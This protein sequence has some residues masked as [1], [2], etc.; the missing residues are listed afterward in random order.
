MFVKE[1]ISFYSYYQI[2]NNSIIK[3]KVF[4]FIFITLDSIILLIKII[5]I[6]HTNYNINPSSIKYINLSYLMSEFPIIIKLL[7]LIIYLILGYVIIII[8]LLTSIQK[9]V[10]KCDKIVINIFEFFIIR[11]LFIFIFEL[12]FDLSSYLFFLFLILSMPFL[13]FIFFNF[14]F[15]H[16]TGFMLKIVEFPYDNFS[17]ICE[18]QKTFIKIIIAISETTQ[19]AI[20]SK[21]M[22]FFQF[23]IMIICLIY[24]TYVIF[25]K[26]YYLMN[27]ELFSKTRYSN[28]LSSVVIQ[29]FMFLLK[30]E[31]IYS[32]S[33]IINFIGIYILIILFIFL[34]YNPYNY[35][36]IDTAEN[37]ENLYYY[38]FLMDRDKNITIFLEEKI[39]KHIDKCN[40]CS[41]CDKYQ[42]YIN[43]NIIEFEND[44]EKDKN[45]FNILYNGND[46]SLF[47]FN[48]MITNVKKYGINF[49]YHN[50]YY[51]INLINLFYY[52]YKLGDISFSLNLLLIFNL[53]QDNY[54]TIITNHKITIRQITYLNEFLLLYK[55]I[56]SEIKGII[57]VNNIKR[58][59][60]KFFNLSQDLKLLSSSKYKEYLY[61][62][63]VKGVTNYS[64]LLTIS[65]L[66]YEEIFNKSISIYGIPVRENTQLHE[67]ALKNFF[68]HNNHIVL[69]FNLKTKEC[70]ILFAGTDLYSYANTNFYDLF[71]NQMKEALIQSFCNVLLNSNENQSLKRLNKH[72][73]QNRRQYIELNLI[74]K[75]TLEN[76]N[77]FWVLFLKLSLLFNDHMKEEIL[78]NGF[79]SLSKNNL[80]TVKYEKKK[81]KIV[82][83]G[84]KSIMEAVIKSK[85]LLNVFKTSTF[86]VNK[87]IQ[88]LNSLFIG[89]IQYIVY[90]IKDN[91]KKVQIKSVSRQ[92]TN[93]KHFLNNTGE[94]ESE[95]FSN[96][97]DNKYENNKN[98]DYSSSG[99]KEDINIFHDSASQTSVK[100]KSSGSS[101]WNLNKDMGKDHQNSFSSNKFLKLQIILGVLLISSL[102]FM[103]V[104]I[105]QLKILQNS[106]SIY[107]NSFFNL[108]QFIRTFHQ[109]S[110]SL[111]TVACIVKNSSDYCESYISSL[112]TEEFNQTTFINE[113][114]EVLAEYCSES[115]T[116]IIVS[117]EVIKDKLLIEL[118]KGSF[119]YKI[120]NTKKVN[121]TYNI[122]HSEID[123]YLNDALLLLSNNMRIIVSEESKIKTR[124]KEPIY[125]VSGF[126]N[127]FTNIRN[128]SSELSDYQISVYTYIIN[129][130]SFVQRFS[131]LNQRSNELI[132]IKNRQLINI[133]TIFH[134]IIFIIM[135]LQIVTIVFYIFTFNTLLAFIINSIICKF[136]IIYD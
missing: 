27:N 16:L 51:N 42:Q 48:N 65:S 38:F 99:D 56:L 121:N 134:N 82:G 105:L 69:N 8:Y 26:S 41:L 14:S 4:H 89:N 111:F 6:Y 20:L 109:F 61:G 123:I 88:L 10:N 62:T 81:E 22:F 91:K 136:D 15:F 112:D 115:I 66:L 119:S 58:E 9:L 130:R 131:N 74:I 60:N 24:N 85:F 68:R 84:N 63:K 23:V 71:P 110:Y 40:S 37:K 126:E 125:L 12:L 34:F 31:E 53:I 106:I 29:L 36:I 54:H 13:A 19:S 59:I 39:K 124:N 96:D 94:L 87:K 116:Q 21:L 97:N 49:L 45:L 113:F 46:K 128:T 75:K 80:L 64:Y 100:T 117:S 1:E 101:L 2:L 47:L 33:Y 86:M 114:N 120:M 17:S 76:S 79:F 102:I 52:S 108:S 43:N 30:P 118:L 93:V 127:P 57:K 132:N 73:K 133:V 28:L 77:F 122:T 70:K 7:P 90:F 25:Y 50:S 67:D 72:S 18:V 78:F 92:S 44:P 5:D 103:I 3:S 35:I 129:Y 32:K 98:S 55:K 11:F 107:I 104:L 95:E 83:Y 135:I